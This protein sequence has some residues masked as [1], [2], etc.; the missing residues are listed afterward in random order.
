MRSTLK[1]SPLI[2]AGRLCL[3]VLSIVFASIITSTAF[4]TS[5]HHVIDTPPNAGASITFT[6]DGA[7]AKL[8]LAYNYTSNTARPN[9]L[10]IFFHY[11]GGTVN[12][13]P[14]SGFKDSL[15]NNG[16]SVAT[17]STGLS[18]GSPAAQLLYLHLFQYVKQNYNF[19]TIPYLI[20]DSM[21]TLASLNVIDAK[22]IP[23]RSYISICPVVGLYNYY[24]HWYNIN[25]KETSHK[26]IETTYGFTAG[27]ANAQQSVRNYDPFQRLTISNGDTVYNTNNIPTYFIQG[28]ADP[29]IAWTRTM[30]RASANQTLTEVPGF[31]HDTLVLNAARINT[32]INWMAHAGVSSNTSLSGLTLSAATVNPA[33]PGTATNF[34]AGV[35]AAT[36]SVTVKATAVDP[37][38]TISINGIPVKNGSASGSIALNTG[39]NNIGITVT[40]QDGVTIKNYTLAI[41]KAPPSTNANLVIRTNTVLTRVG[42]TLNYTTSVLYTA[43]SIIVTATAVD[44]TATIKINGVVTQSGT[45]VTIPLITGVNTIYIE[46]IAQNGVTS[47]MYSIAVTKP[48]SPNA[49]LSLRANTPLVRVGIT[50]NFTTTVPS[51]IQALT[52]TATAADTAAT[53]KINGV[54]VK[55]GIP[56]APIPLVTGNNTINIVATAPDGTTTKQYTIVATKALSS[57]ANLSFRTNAT[58]VRVGSTNNFTASVPATVKTLIIITTAADTTASILLNGT[59]IKSGVASP[60]FNLSIGLNTFNITATA[61]DGVTTNSYSI[62]VTR[63]K[64]TNANLTLR[65]VTPLVRVETS[66]NFT[67]S[68]TNATKTI[69]VT[70][71]AADTTA[72][73]KVNGMITPSGVPSSPIA[74]LTGINTINVEATAQDGITVKQYSIAVTRALSSNATLTLKTGTSLARVGTSNNY[75][76]SVPNTIK[77]IAVTAT[78]ADTTAV[79]KINGVVTPSGIASAPVTLLA[80]VNTINIEA[81]A[82]DG[83]TTKQYTIAVTRA[84]S[85]NANLSSLSVAG[86]SVVHIGGTLNY[87]TTVKSTTNS[88]SVSAIAADTT[89][90]VTINNLPAAKAEAISVSLIADTT[91]IPV[92]ITAQDGVTSRTFLITVFKPVTPAPFATRQATQTDNTFS[93]ANNTDL[94]AP[95]EVSVHKAVSPNGDGINDQLQISGIESYP[96]NRLTII[97]SSGI[98]VFEISG[99]D[100]NARAFNG[101]SNINGALNPAGTYFYL[102]QYNANG[103][104]KNSNGY[105]VLKY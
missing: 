39:V 8:L 87:K 96:D 91:D 80:G 103:K 74:L 12:S 79:I 21:G 81:I 56:S 13:E 61:Q 68:V 20:A 14:P 2:N 75:T 28:T 42:T 97:N 70:A 6:I 4:A 89:A 24:A 16:Y 23:A 22:S 78:A 41:T 100:N 83:V 29:Y 93:I 85:A 104:Q 43:P 34:T 59:S 52:V 84:L 31:G 9:K 76:T 32:L 38:A 67:T 45:P 5:N 105:F 25:V 82:Q 33:T 99:Y 73:I 94:S 66:D 95:G 86:F 30:V 58:L 7:P 101:R 77:T 63:L 54:L 18:W 98:K 49:N 27:L 57:N 60:A 102:L 71:I 3:Q 19:Q 35:S 65:T 10:V 17:I 90:S 47:K 36:S 50:N 69:A 62:A 26:S 37:D 53:I 72:R 46:G 92:V 44:T 40:A 64:S 1:K 15:R 11:Y 48:L 51:G 55:T 88:V